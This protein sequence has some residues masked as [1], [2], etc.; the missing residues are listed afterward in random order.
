[1]D[2]SSIVTPACLAGLYNITGFTPNPKKANGFMG[3]NGFLQQ[4]ARYSDLAAFE[5][6]YA[7]N[8]KGA[9]FTWTS[10]KG[11]PHLHP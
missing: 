2:C 5:N 6:E 9:N 11:S 7:P 3:V 4:Y 8:A 1:M 10:I